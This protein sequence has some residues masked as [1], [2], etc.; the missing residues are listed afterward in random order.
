MCITKRM[1]K[2][3]GTF[4]KHPYNKPACT[5]VK[6][7]ELGIHVSLW[8]KVQNNTLYCLWIYMYNKNIKPCLGWKIPNLG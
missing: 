5:T 8:I 6:M 2:L 3:Y 7:N 1:Y 4:I